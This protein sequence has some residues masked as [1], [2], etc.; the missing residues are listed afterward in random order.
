MSGNEPASCASLSVY[1]EGVRSTFTER[2]YAT[3][4][5][6][7]YERLLAELSDW[8]QSRGLEP[9]QLTGDDVDGF[10]WSR[11]AAAGSSAGAV[12]GLRTLLGYLRSV[13]AVPAAQRS[14]SET[15]L[16]T[17][18]DYLRGQRRL[19]ER[20]AVTRAEVIRRFLAGLGDDGQLDLSGLTV[21]DVH[22]FVLGEAGRLSPRSVGPVLDSL[23]SFL[24][25]LFA[26]G[27]ADHDLSGTL[28]AVNTRRHAS[29]PRTVDAGTVTALLEGCQRSTVVG[30]RDYAILTLL[31]RFGL[32]ANEVAAMRLEDIDWRAGELTV[33]GKGGR[34][35]RMPLPADV[36]EALVAYLRHR[37]LLR[38]AGAH[39]AVFLRAAPP[40]GALSRNG[41]VMV[42][43]TASRRAG[44]TVVGAH[45]LRHTAAAGMLRAGA[46]L[47]EVGQ[48]LRHDRDQTTAIYAT[49][50]PGSLGLVVRA[51]PGAGR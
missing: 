2:G 10:V 19:A 20:T 33:H 14:P 35:D 28:P 1:A 3:S 8:L 32:R 31:V 34:T 25:F 47:R 44:V 42:P 11:P 23:R 26:T 7:R 21:E 37:H 46:S 40:A 22:R 13:G 49:V 36:G 45:R 4:T 15:V 24:R 29:L 27:V 9:A 30:L 18:R 39:R 48:V 50:D 16:D 5:V 38:G 12:Q 51:W 43:R 6:D 41:V 17:F